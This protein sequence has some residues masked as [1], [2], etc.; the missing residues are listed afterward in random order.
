MSGETPAADVRLLRRV[1]WRLVAW[2]GGITLLILVAL[3]AILLASLT[4]S[5]QSNGERLLRDA[6]RNLTDRIDRGPS[7]FPANPEGDLP[8]GLR[9]GGPTSGTLALIVAAD[10]RTFGF[11]PQATVGGL[12]DPA[13]LAAARAGAV[14]IRETRVG[15]V[16]VRILSQAIVRGGAQFVVQIVGDRTAE[17]RTLGIVTAVLAIGGVAGVL[18]AIGGGWLYAR[19]ALVPIRESLRRQRA[20]AAD[21]SHEL[22]TPLAIVRGS[23]EHL[24]RHP[25]APVGSVGT[26]LEDIRSE[27]DHVTQLVES[28]L[29]LARAD[30]G[31]AEVQAL[32]VDLADVTTGALGTLTQLARER[33]AR[34][35]LDATATPVTGDPVRLRQLVTILVDN[36]LRHSPTGEAVEVRVAARD[37]RA[38]LSVADHGPG[39]RAEDRAH[40]FDRF[41]RASD[42]PAGGVGLGLSIA[43]WIAEGHA[44]T[45]DVVSG[46]S[47]GATFTIRL[48]LSTGAVVPDAAVEGLEGPPE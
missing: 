35:D 33:G 18:L 39:I 21:A 12:P 4:Q 11:G 46:E 10:G 32:P 38:V 1:R 25:E 7:G 13:G 31:A 45:I 22:R 36:A 14:D 28:L 30:S 17:E 3:G 37:G 43:A 27:V 29:L 20:F 8:L 41:W 19:R 40:V 23:V 15:D 24:L 5:F 44:G 48:P 2:S 47:G 42:A 9:F 16:P 6:A 34:L 26:A